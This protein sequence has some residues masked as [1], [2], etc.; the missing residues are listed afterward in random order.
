MSRGAQLAAGRGFEPAQA[1]ADRVGMA[2]E[3]GGGGVGG[4]PGVE[5]GL[6]RVKQNGSFVLGHRVEAAEHALADVAHDVGVA[7]CGHDDGLLIEDAD[8]LVCGSGAGERDPRHPHPRAGQSEIGERGA[9]SVVLVA[10]AGQARVE[11]VGATVW[12]V[13]D[14]DE[15]VGQQLPGGGVAVGSQLH[16][17]VGHRVHAGVGCFCDDREVG[18]LGGQA[19]TGGKAGEGVAVGERPS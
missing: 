3:L 1:V 9:E 5:P 6:K 10:V 2:E 12:E 8:V 16:L 18:A 7:D 4:A 13:H 17:D 19:Q 11:S 15:R 14:A